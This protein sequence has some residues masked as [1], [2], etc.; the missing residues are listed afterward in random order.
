LPAMVAQQLTY[1][2]RGGGPIAYVQPI[3]GPFVL[4]NT[5]FY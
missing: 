2:G 4:E 3:R 5:C 1:F